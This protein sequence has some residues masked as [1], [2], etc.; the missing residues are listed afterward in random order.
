MSKRDDEIQSYLDT[1]CFKIREFDYSKGVRYAHLLNGRNEKTIQ[2]LGISDKKTVLLLA[3]VLYHAQ[4]CVFAHTE[5]PGETMGKSLAAFFA[6][7]DPDF[8][9]LGGK[10][11]ESWWDAFKW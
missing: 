2:M 6:Y 3:D 10:G 5:Q 8:E 11:H 4:L 1:G 7:V 9:S